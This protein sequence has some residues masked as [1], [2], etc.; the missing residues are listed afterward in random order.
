MSVPKVS[1][2]TLLVLL[3]RVHRSLHARWQRAGSPVHATELLLLENDRFFATGIASTSALLDRLQ[4]TTEYLHT[5]LD[6]TTQPLP[7]VRQL[8]AEAQ[9]VLQ[10]TPPKEFA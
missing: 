5:W 4:E 7:K 1:Q 9:H 2:H 3:Q 10:A 6:C 8:V